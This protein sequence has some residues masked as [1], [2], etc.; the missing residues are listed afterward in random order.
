[1]CVHRDNITT[2]FPNEIVELIR[3]RVDE[4]RDLRRVDSD[5]FVRNIVDEPPDDDGAA[6]KQML[7]DVPVDAT[8]DDLYVST[9]FMN[10]IPPA[11]VRLD[12][13]DSEN[14]VTKVMRLDTD[15]SKVELLSQFGKLAHRDGLTADDLDSIEGTLDTLQDFDD[16]DDVD[17]LDQFIKQ[18]FL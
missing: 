9:L 6:L 4:N 18:T 10:L 5:R 17:D 8:E 12:D 2:E 7:G 3:V 15:V 13:P 16:I 1:V 14:V 11:F